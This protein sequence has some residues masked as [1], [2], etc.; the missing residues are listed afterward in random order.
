[1]SSSNNSVPDRRPATTLAERRPSI[2]PLPARQPNMTR[3][4]EQR[5][6]EQVK[7]QVLDTA[8]K[9]FDQTLMIIKN[10]MKEESK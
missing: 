1:M 7:V 6:F 9:Y 3:K 10:W 4:Q 2:L 8:T 5:L